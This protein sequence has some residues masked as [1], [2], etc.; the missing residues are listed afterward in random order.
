MSD[1]QRN[2]IPLYLADC[3]IYSPIQI[4]N[5]K[6]ISA[7]YRVPFLSLVAFIFDIFISA[8]KHEHKGIH[9]HNNLK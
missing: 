7:F 8:Y 4:I 1:T 9:V 3:L 6:Y 5:F 2:F